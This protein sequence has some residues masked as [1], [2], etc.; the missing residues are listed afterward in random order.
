MEERVAIIGAGL[1]GRAWTIVF[2]RS[3]YEV[4]LY[5]SAVDIRVDI[6][7]RLGSTLSDLEAME[8][9]QPYEK[10]S[11]MSRV[12]VH[13]DLADALTGASYIQEA[14]GETLEAKRL[15]FGR[16]EALADPMAILASSS[17]ALLPSQMFTNM[18]HEDRCLVV[19]PVNPP[20]LVPFVE[21]VPGP[22]TS[23]STVQKVK[24][25]MVAIKQKPIVLA[26]EYPGFV[27]NRLQVALVNEAISIVQQGIASVADVDDAVKFGL[28]RRW[29]FMGPFETIDLNAPGGIR[30]FLER[31][32]SMYLLAKDFQAMA[33]FSPELLTYLETARRSLVSQDQLKDRMVWRDR[34][35]MK[36][37]KSLNQG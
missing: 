14:I 4:S 34:E 2:A 13:S 19:H 29:A 17:S 23:S 32:E 9:I 7:E 24:K 31:F 11:I 5:D 1:I 6:L 12:T 25:L 10:A 28:G 22:H 8:L 18:L 36:I 26:Q 21:I 16:L 30:D 20:F 37:T 35:L 33:P 3:E 27:L 15:V